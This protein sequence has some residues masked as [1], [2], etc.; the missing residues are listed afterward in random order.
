MVVFRMELRTIREYFGVLLF[1]RLSLRILAFAIPLFLTVMYNFWI[2]MKV[3][4]WVLLMYIAL[5]GTLEPIILLFTERLMGTI[6]PK[7]YIVLA[8]IFEFPSTVVEL[9]TSG[10]TFEYIPFL[11]WAL[12][13]YFPVF[14]IAFVV[15]YGS[16]GRQA[17][18]KSHGE[19]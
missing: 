19:V 15:F 9:L 11:G 2:F 4:G 12:L 16:R 1:L 13:W 8:I 3:P 5:M 17:L 18:N 6:L 7:I 14:L 10:W